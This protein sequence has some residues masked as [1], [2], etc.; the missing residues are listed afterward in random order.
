MQKNI[1]SFLRT[2]LLF[3]CQQTTKTKNKENKQTGFSQKNGLFE[4]RLC[5]LKQMDQSLNHSENI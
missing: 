4:R 5:G 2:G 1:F 3:N